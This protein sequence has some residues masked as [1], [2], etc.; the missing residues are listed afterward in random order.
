MQSIVDEFRGSRKQELKD[1]HSLFL[2]IIARLEDVYQVRP[3][4]QQTAQSLTELFALV[5][6]T[7]P[8]IIFELGAG[9]RSSTL[10]LSLA[11]ARMSPR[12]PIFSLDVAPVD[13][14]SLARTHFPD[15]RFAPVHDIATEAT[16]FV[17]PHNWKHP[18]FMLYDAHDDDLPGIKIFSHARRSWFPA[19]PGAVI[20]VHDCSVYPEPQADLG[21]PYHQAVYA[22]DVTLAG[23]GE[24]PALVDFLHQK[25]LSLGFP[26]REMEVLGI[27]GEGTSLVYFRLPEP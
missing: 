4:N 25:A 5:Q 22:P 20:A 7:Q 17:I 6:A 10:A 24:V 14:Q 19:M 16:R 1:A 9:S 26:G 11:A 8:Q 2:R 15:L 18:I 3:F 21:Q 23:Y 12:P 13:F 27:G